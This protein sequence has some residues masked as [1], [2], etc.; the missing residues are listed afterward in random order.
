V[1][2]VCLRVILS[3]LCFVCRSFPIIGNLIWQ[4]VH[5]IFEAS[6]TLA[7]GIVENGSLSSEGQQLSSARRFFLLLL[8]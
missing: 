5:L 7:A 1:V 8:G 2:S 6:T 4:L 3:L